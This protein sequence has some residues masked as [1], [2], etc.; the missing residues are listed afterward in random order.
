M[1]CPYCHYEVEQN[2]VFCKNCGEKI[3]PS[4]KEE[5]VSSPPIVCPFCQ[6]EIDADSVYCE[7]CGKQI[8]N[9][10]NQQEISFEQQSEKQEETAAILPDK[11]S[12]ED[13]KSNSILEIEPTTNSDT[14]NTVENESISLEWYYFYTNRLVPF[15]L[16]M[17]I[18]FIALLIFIYLDSYYYDDFIA[19]VV[20]IM[21]IPYLITYILLFLI[22]KEIKAF[23]EKGLKHFMAY[24]TCLILLAVIGIMLM[25]QSVLF[26]IGSI[27]FR[28]ANM[29]YFNKRKHL[30]IN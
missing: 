11:E 1:Q 9:N 26:S 15:I 21:A 12:L 13:I 27:V 20:P 4:K 28:Y 8:Q 5:P 30:F 17:A 23:K 16:I 19:I 25:P 22:W 10:N 18:L 3:L 7:H 2:S 14:N 24:N 29:N 6:K